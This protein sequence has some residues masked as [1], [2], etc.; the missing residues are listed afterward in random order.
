[1]YLSALKEKKVN[2]E[3]K[4]VCSDLNGWEVEMIETIVVR[5]LPDEFTATYEASGVWNL[6]A[7]HF[8]EDGPGETRWVIDNEFKMKG[9]MMLMGIFMQGT[10][11]SRRSNI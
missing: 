4:H 6:N 9:L 7:N 8:Y 3:R 1:M 5:D 11:P 10:F 2:Q